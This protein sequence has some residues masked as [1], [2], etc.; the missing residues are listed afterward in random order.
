MLIISALDLLYPAGVPQPFLSHALPLQQHSI[1]GQPFIELRHRAPDSRVRLPYPLGSP[2]DQQQN[3]HSQQ[4][5][6]AGMSGMDLLYQHQG[7]AAHQQPHQPPLGHHGNMSQGGDAGLPGGDG[8][9]EHLEGEDSA[10]KDLEDVEVK[11]LVDLNLNLDPEDGRKSSLLAR[12]SLCVCV[13]GLIPGHSDL[14][15]NILIIPVD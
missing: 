13:R 6:Q 3:P 8:M 11:D 10:V 5:V 14:G 1:M 9:E 15:L 12:V 7:L 4:G 2:M